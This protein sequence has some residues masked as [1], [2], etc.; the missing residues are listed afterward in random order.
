MRVAVLGGGI[1][2][3]SCSQR[4]E[5]KGHEVRCFESL[6][7]PGGLCRSE[8]VDGFVADRA[9]GHI[10]FSKDQ[11]VLDAMLRW[12][13]PAGHHTSRRR[14][15]IYHRGRFVQYPFE[16]G[17]ADLGREETAACLLDYLEAAFA[18]RQGAPCPGDFHGWCLWR[19]GKSI[20]DLFMHPYNDKIWNVPLTELGTRWVEGRVPDAPMEDVVRAALGLRTE[21]YA[22][23]STFHYPLEG[24]FE[25]VVRGVAAALKP[26]T[27]LLETPVQSLARSGPGFLVN[28]Q[29]FDRVVST[30]PLP[31]LAGILQDPPAGVLEAIRALDHTALMTVFIA[32]SKSD[33]PPHSWIYFPH[34]EDGPQNRITWL[35]NYSPRNA[36]EGK[37]SIMAEVTYHGTPPG[38]DDSVTA[39]VVSGLSRAG[40]FDPS[41]VM[42]T[43]VWHNRFAYILYRHGLEE[44]LELIRSFAKEQGIDLAGRFGNYSYFNSDRCIRDAWDLADSYPPA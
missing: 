36:P 11:E 5:A 24:G 38:D 35:S 30:I 22:H 20:C 44:H 43:R 2:G 7:R 13:E 16:N 21:G 34:R 4:L 42:F 32:L 15:F 3:L 31:L 25:S 18:R 27:L 28:G 40:F 10:I 26:G 29:P 1:T 23:Q 39:E 41:E 19:F 9:G 6:T 33:P 17:L 12:L 8:T 37:S 14:T